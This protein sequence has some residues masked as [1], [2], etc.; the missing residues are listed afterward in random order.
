MTNLTSAEG[1]VALAGIA[2][3]IILV[4]AK[5]FHRW[6]SVKP[7]PDPWGAEVDAAL[8]NPEVL[9]VCFHCSA[10]H[11]ETAWFCPEC[12]AAVGEYNNWNPYLYIF[13]LG[14]VLRAGTFG[15]CQRSWFVMLG[16]LILSLAE[17]TI[18]APV[19]WLLLFRNSSRSLS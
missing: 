17:Y 14:E 12:G 1:L 18:F 19:Y 2:V 5:V 3:V 16:Y 4:A 15:K 8:E 7:K 6:W 9:P 11:T 13:S 10:P